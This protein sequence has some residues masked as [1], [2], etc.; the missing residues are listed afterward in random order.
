MKYIR[1]VTV[2]VRNSSGIFWIDFVL[3]FSPDNLL[4][5]LTID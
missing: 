2:L 5:I 3:V 1:L 4:I